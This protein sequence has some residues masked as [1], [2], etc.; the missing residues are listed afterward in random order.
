MAMVTT[1]VLTQYGMEVPNAYFR[2]NNVIVGRNQADRVKFLVDI[3][4]VAFPTQ[5]AA[6]TAEPVGNMRFFVPLE[7]IEAQEGAD[8]I[9]KC[10]NWLSAKPE[11]ENSTPV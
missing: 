1:L 7:E 4:V 8:I 11:F 3:M 10:Y 9:A 2:V 6:K 5:E